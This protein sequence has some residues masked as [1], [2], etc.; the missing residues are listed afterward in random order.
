MKNDLINILADNSK[1]IDNQMLMDYISGKLSDPDQHAVEE[2]TQNNQF[3][4]DALEG[5]QQFGNQEQLKNYVQQLN[6]ELK[7]FLQQK[8]QKREKRRWKDQPFTYIA[9]V[10]ILCLA[11]IAYILLRLLP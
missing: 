11:V 6:L 7:E 4:T 8:R 1:D 5:L 10:F 3:A 2:W 9:I